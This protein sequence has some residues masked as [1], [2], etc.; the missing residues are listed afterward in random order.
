[1]CIICIIL[2]KYNSDP[3]LRRYIYFINCEAKWGCWFLCPTFWDKYPDLFCKA[4]QNNLKYVINEK[5]GFLLLVICPNFLPLNSGH[6]IS[7]YA[8]WE[9]TNQNPNVSISMPCKQKQN[10]NL[11][12]I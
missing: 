8:Y 3:N 2:Y 10:I 5:D 6:R 1:M 12:L 9:Y 11:S 4:S 7:V